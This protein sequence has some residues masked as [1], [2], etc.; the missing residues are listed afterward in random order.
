MTVPQDSLPLAQ[1]TPRLIGRKKYIEQ[2]KGAITNGDERSYVFYLIGPGGIGKTRILE[3]VRNIQLEWDGAPFL[4]SGVIDLYHTDYHSPSGLREG[5]ARG[6]DPKEQYFQRYWKKRAEFQKKR[7]E[8]VAGPELERL[9]QQLDEIF[10]QEYAQLAKKQRVVLC[11]DTLELIQ[12]ES[13][14][15]QR[16]CKVQDVDTLIKSWLLKNVSQ[17]QNTVTLFA[18]RP[19][20]RT[21]ADFKKGFKKLVFKQLTLKALTNEEAKEYLALMRQRRPELDE[22]LTRENQKII[23]KMAEGRPIHLA[24]FIDLLSYNGVPLDLKEFKDLTSTTSEP[25]E[26]KGSINKQ[27]FEYFLNL[28]SPF[29]D[30]IYFLIRTRKGLDADLLSHLTKWPERE[31]QQ[32]IE[33]M[34][35]FALVKTRPGTDQLF[36]HDELYDLF[37]LYFK[38]DPQRSGEYKSIA[39]Y[40]QEKLK[41]AKSIDDTEE[42]MLALLYYQL[43]VDPYKGYYRYYARWDEEAIRGH[44][45]GFDMRLRDEVLRFLERYTTPTSDF[46]DKRVADR[47]D[48]NAVDRDC[49]VRWVKRYVVRNDLNT[50]LEVA[51]ELRS[52]QKD[53]I[54]D[55]GSLQDVFYKAGLL[56]ASSEAMLYRG[57]PVEQTLATLEEAVTLLE[58]HGI[59]DDDEQWWQ[60][61]LLGRVYNN[62]GY[63]Y[64]AQGRYGSALQQFRQALPQFRE[65]RIVDEEARTRNNLAFLLAVLGRVD[66]A[67]AHIERTVEVRQRR[68]RRY[69]IALSLNTRGIIYT[70]DD[71]PMWGLRDCGEALQIST[72]LD[73]PRG[74]GLANNALGFAYRKLGDQWKRGRYTPEEAE[75]YFRKAQEYLQE[76]VDIFSKRITE[77]IR[78]WEAYNELGSLFCDW[79]WLTYH[80]PDS[81]NPVAALEQY[82]QSISYQQQALEIALKRDLQFQTIDS[83]DDLAQVHGDQTFLF[84]YMG[85]EKEANESRAKAETYLQNIEQSIPP[86]FYLVPGEGFR[87]TTEAG[88]AYWL[89]LSKAYLWRGIWAFRDLL[90]A[91]RI[92]E[93]R[94]EF[95]LQQATQYLLFSFAYSRRFWPASYALKHTLNYFSD[96]LQRAGVSAEWAHTQTERLAGE[97]N[98]DFQ[99][100]SDTID[101]RLGV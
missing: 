34:R 90:E 20:P 88:E 18:G 50:A 56:A 47:I 92:P 63:L 98:L 68:A 17:F 78:L 81:S 31:I 69:P 96:F 73:E 77:P 3:E 87:E 62:L 36:L 65:A 27:F 67:L 9:R 8:G 49:A 11:F 53:P 72:Q 25:Q 33:Q 101:N 61:L 32:I 21:Q 83:Y 99:M 100:I 46:Y 19:R 59:K 38:D 58:N 7:E 39:E 37:D 52:H 22:F 55:W 51:H 26:V 66:D 15:V 43:Q 82:Q 89:S 5:I 79:G 80:R 30:M 74:V 84:F 48:R 76:A 29:Y 64:Q 44:E 75:A 54:F 14:A 93:Q 41:R 16:I 12:Y 24:L 85:K 40:Y 6:L 71:H 95:T 28:P 91:E 42:F 57:D 4:Y 94:Q 86:D 13:D 2:I 97:Y 45:T 70:L 60:A 10:L 1:R 23:I 35:S